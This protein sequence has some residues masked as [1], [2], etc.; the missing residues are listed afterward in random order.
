PRLAPGVRLAGQ[1]QESAFKDPPWLIERDGAGYVQV[2]ELLYHVAEL[3]TG[4]N[5]FEAIAAGLTAAGQPVR[6][7]TIQRLVAQ[8]LIPLGLVPTADGSVAQVGRQ[9]SSLLAI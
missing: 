9:R 3:C 4:E 2:T 7:D 6:P 1:M 8:M 5:T